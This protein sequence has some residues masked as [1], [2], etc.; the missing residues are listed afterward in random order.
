MSTPW[1][2]EQAQWLQ[3]MGHQVWT[4]AGH[5]AEAAP[6]SGAIAEAAALLDKAAPARPQPVREPVAA[7]TAAPAA[8]RL[9]HAI[10]R[11]ANRTVGDEA[12]SALLQEA[13]ALRGNAAAKRALW[14]RLRRLRRPQEGP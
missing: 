1:S 13:P 7:R 10:L 3:A 11:A 12:V 9:V 4:L 6:Q 14:P 5:G 8:D 2:A